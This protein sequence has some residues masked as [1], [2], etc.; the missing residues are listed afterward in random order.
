M[1]KIISGMDFLNR[2]SEM[3]GLPDHTIGIKLTA[4]YDSITKV[5]VEYYPNLDLDE[6]GEL[7]KAFKE[8]ELKPIEE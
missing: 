5:E 6:N 7:I 1:S 3:L 2:F 4:Y 8:Y